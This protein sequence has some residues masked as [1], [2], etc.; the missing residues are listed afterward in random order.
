MTN[1]DELNMQQTEVVDE[2]QKYIDTINQMKA[3]S[4]S[5]SDYDKVR[6][7][8][9]KLLEAMVNGKYEESSSTEDT[10]KPSIQDLR[11]KAYGK[12]SENLSDLEYVTTVLDLRDALLE[13]E[14][15][16]H[17]IPS[18]K[19]YSPDLND[20]HCAQKAYEALRHCVD[21]ADGDNEV[22]IQEITRI[23]VDNGPKLPNKTNTYNRR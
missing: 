10:A 1:N 19:K 7:E 4:V 14:G 6:D 15:I 13:E 12:G 8:N 18:G 16:D 21:V 2:T 9:K 11:N 5:R 3:N 22:F 23:T 20:Q 17:M